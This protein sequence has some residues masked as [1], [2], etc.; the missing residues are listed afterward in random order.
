MEPR[1]Y[2]VETPELTGRVAITLRPRGFE[3]LDADVA[4]WKAS[5][6][7]VVVSLLACE[8]AEAIG[9]G[10]QGAACQRQ[11]IAFVACPVADFSVPLSM[12]D[13]RRIVE[14]LGHHLDAGRTLAFHCFAS[15]G[16]SPTLAAAVLVRQGLAADDAIARLSTARGLQVPETEQQKQW[17]FDFARTPRRT[18]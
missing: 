5:G 16:R 12:D 9:L 15:R 17:I 14:D 10:E 1:L 18:R 3:F 6:V 4:S 11:G 8:E 13:A 7:D 2:W